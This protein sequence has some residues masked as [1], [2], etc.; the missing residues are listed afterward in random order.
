MFHTLLYFNYLGMLKIVII[1]SFPIAA[2]LQSTFYTMFNHFVE[3]LDLC[4]CNL[5]QILKWWIWLYYIVLI[6]WMLNSRFNVMLTS[7]YE[8]INKEIEV[9]GYS[10]S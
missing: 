7:Q 1:L 6:S 9:F 5:Q 4:C 8:D 2:I 10:I 3:F